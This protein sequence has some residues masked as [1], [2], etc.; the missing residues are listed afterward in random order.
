MKSM[1]WASPNSTPWGMPRCAGAEQRRGD[2]A[3]DGGVGGA[4]FLGGEPESWE[5]I[6]M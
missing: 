1:R 5:V 4:E 3:G 6:G 2:V